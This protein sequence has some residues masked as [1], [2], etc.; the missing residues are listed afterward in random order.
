MTYRYL[1]EARQELEDAAERY[2][3]RS[4]RTMFRFLD[5]ADRRVRQ[6][7]AQPRMFGRV[8]GRVQGREIRE[9]QI[10]RYSYKL[11]YEVR[12]GEAVVL[13]V[14]HTRRNTQPWTHRQP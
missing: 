2:Y 4:A 10:G 11:V 13:S 9:V 1:P 3:Q 6:I 12:P 14:V 7:A 5:A 8:A